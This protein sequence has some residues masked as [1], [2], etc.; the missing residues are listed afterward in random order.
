MAYSHHSE[1]IVKITEILSK[2]EDVLAVIMG[3]SIAHKTE[4]EDSDID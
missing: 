2:R 3:G 4:R 1:G